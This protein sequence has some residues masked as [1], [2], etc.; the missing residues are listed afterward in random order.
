[1]DARLV[2]AYHNQDNFYSIDLPKKLMM[3]FLLMVEYYS[4]VWI[5]HIFCVHSSVERHLGCF[6]FLAIKNK[7]AVNIIEHVSL[8][9]ESICPS[10]HDQECYRWFTSWKNFFQFSEKIPN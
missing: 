6:S 10:V 3:F 1:M 5:C 9:D 2:L 7:D 4:I 8:W